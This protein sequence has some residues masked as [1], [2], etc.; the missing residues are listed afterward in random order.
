MMEIC[1]LLFNKMNTYKKE[2]L[3]WKDN[4]NW[5]KE[6]KKKFSINLMIKLKESPNSLKLLKN[7]KLN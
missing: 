2:W 3:N 4:Q 6:K 5:K 7:W 1:E